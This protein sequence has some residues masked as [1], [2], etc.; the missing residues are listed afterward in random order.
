MYQSFEIKDFRCFHKL[1]ISDL[2]RVNLIA[3]TNNVGKTAL[4]EALFLHC[5]AYNPELI[6]K[7]NAWRGIE[8]IKIE[9]GMWAETP[10]DLIFHQLDISQDIELIGNNKLTGRRLLRLKIIRD[11]LELSKIKESLP[12]TTNNAEK[13]LSSL[14]SAQVIGLE[15]EELQKHGKYYLI[16]DPKG[17]RTEPIPP[18]PP[19]PTFLQSA[20]FRSSFKEEA[21]RF[22]KLQLQGKED[23]LIKVLQLIEPRIRNL[24]MVVVA[25][26]P[27]IHGDIGL[28]RPLPLPAM[29]EGMVRLVSLLLLIGNAPTGVVLVD[30]IENGLHHSIM[31]KIWRAIGEVAREFNTQLFAT[32]HSLEC[33]IAAH[34]AFKEQGIY[35]FRLHRLDRLKDT[36]KIVTYDQE[37]L[38]ASIESGLE[39]R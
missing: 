14:E 34:K 18:P 12:Y 30:E 39:V 33:I 19:F 32:T 24:K 27:I 20:R 8:T 37:T 16:F 17:I 10:W 36:I 35:D 9:L 13:I 21:E 3:G 11:P 38:E 31:A 1:T 7:I 2:E 29:G 25:G 22:G 23:V 4:L 5:G 28:R 6:I 15:F 26:E